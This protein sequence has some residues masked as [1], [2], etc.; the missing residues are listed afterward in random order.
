MVVRLRGRSQLRQRE[1]S[2]VVAS[3]TSVVVLCFGLCLTPSPRVCVDFL[4]TD[5]TWEYSIL[6]VSSWLFWL[7]VSQGVCLHPFIVFGAS[8]LLLASLGGATTRVR[9]ARGGSVRP[10][11][12]QIENNK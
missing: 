5:T 2:L 1:T 11:G 3:S 12:T 8:C 6:R 4:L 7:Y 10:N 9:V